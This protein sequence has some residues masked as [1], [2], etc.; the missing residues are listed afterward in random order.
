MFDAVK[1]FA[2][3]ITDPVL[4]ASV[5][6]AG[7]CFITIVTL[8]APALAGDK[9]ASRLKAVA[10]R[11]E[12]LR[13]RSRVNTGKDQDRKLRKGND[14]VFRKLVDR[15]DLQKLLE[16]PNV[17][18]TL[19]QAGLRS[20]KHL[21]TF[22][23]ARFALPIVFFA[24]AL[25]YFFMISNNEWTPMMRLAASMG[26][27]AAGFYLPNVWLINI[28]QKRQQSIMRA[29][30]DALDLLLICVESGMSIELAFQRVSQEIGPASI[31]LAEEFSLTTAE[32]AY[33]P[34]RRMAYENLG[35]RTNHQGVKAVCTALI[36]AERYGTPLGSALR[37]MAKENRDMRMT[38]AE[39]KAAALPPKLTVPMIV[40]FL[41]VL[42]I[43]IL[44]PAYI[45]WQNSNNVG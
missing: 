17:I 1:N 23:F 8:A 11:R 24:G 38:A 35:K 20:P 41:P 44:T 3:W 4:L 43:V 36:Q 30:P 21:T 2:I 27:C 12:D 28:A 42:F 13:R 37:V 15:M 18:A 6:A 25:I 40:F 19:T 14:S 5:L 22:Y 29:F 32:L 39:K 26:A 34:D 45:R 16:D 33:L 10:V 31:E 7:A 9:L